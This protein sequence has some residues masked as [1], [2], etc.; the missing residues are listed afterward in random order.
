MNTKTDLST[1]NANAYKLVE[2][3]DHEDCVG[4]VMTL[5]EFLG[6]NR[7]HAI[8]PYDGCIGAVIVDGYKTNIKVKGWA[9]YGDYD[10]TMELND[11][12]N[13]NGKVEI[14]WCNR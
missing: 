13:I 1:N 8:L 14:E 6:Y 9:M 3:F 11:L 2:R 10:I 5:D 12:K 4:D 7:C